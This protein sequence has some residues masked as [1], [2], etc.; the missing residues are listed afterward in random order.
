MQHFLNLVNY[1]RLRSWVSVRRISICLPIS[2]G[3]TGPYS[4]LDLGHSLILLYG[5]LRAHHHLG[6]L[7]WDNA[8]AADI[9]RLSE[10][11]Q[12]SLAHYLFPGAEVIYSSGKQ[13]HYQGYQL[14]EP[15]LPDHKM[16][17]LEDLD[18]EALSTSS[19]ATISWELTY[20]LIVL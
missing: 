19:L 6:S 5:S 3:G 14:L 1:S 18:L 16:Y 17:L 11:D 13:G 20:R 8:Y 2:A 12:D 15:D 7:G 4:V 9:Q 10:I